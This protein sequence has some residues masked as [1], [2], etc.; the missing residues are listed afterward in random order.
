MVEIHSAVNGRVR[1]RIGKLYRSVH[2][3]DYLERK[4]SE[5]EQIVRATA[6]PLTGTL[7]VVSNG[8][9]T[10]QDIREVV[11]DLLRRHF[12][13]NGGRAGSGMAG[14]SK[15]ERTLVPV[16]SARDDSSKPPGVRR[17]TETFL[18]GGISRQPERTWWH[19]E[20]AE[21][22]TALNTS[23]ETGLSENAARD[24]LK[25]FGPNVLAESRK[26]SVL[27]L[28]LGQ[29]NSLPVALLG[30]AAGVSLLTGG[31]ADALVILSVVGINAAI[32]CATERQAEKTLESLK[33]LVR[34][35]AQVI[36]AGTCRDVDIVRVVPGDLVVLRPGTYVPADCRLVEA[37]HLTVDESA[38]TGESMP[39][40]KACHALPETAIPIGERVNMVH[41]G[42]LVTGGQGI[43]VAVATG[44]YTEIGRI[45]NLVENASAPETPMERQLSQIGNQLVLISSAVCT[46]IFSIGLFRRYGFLEMFKTSIS[47]AVAAVPEGLPT[48]ATTTLAIGI[49]TMRSRK[50]IMRHLEAVE[51]L[52]AIQTI[53]FD[54]TGTVTENRM[55]VRRIFTSMQTV[56]VGGSNGSGEFSCATPAMDPLTCRELIQLLHVSVLCS[57]TAVEQNGT[58]YALHG[59]STE[60][61]LVRTA[62][63][64]GIDPIRLREEYLLLKTNHRSE[65][66]HFMGTLHRS[67]NGGT[68]FALKGS[69]PE[70]LAMCQWQLIDGE[71]VPLTEE[72]RTIIEN[73]NENMAGDALRVLGFAFSE[74]EDGG[75]F[76]SP[77]SLTWL[78]L[79]GMADPIRKGVKE[80]IPLFHDAGIETILIT[81]DQSATAYAIGRELDL[82]RG[83]PLEIL[84]SMCL[85]DLEPDALRALSQ[86]V[87]VFSRVSPA[88]KLQIVQALQTAGKIVAMTGD[89]IND[90]PALKAADVGVALGGSGTD[91]AREVA[92]VVL[93]D[94]NLETMI[95]AVSHGRTV[96]ANIRK[97]IHF[98]LATNFSEIMLMFVGTATGLGSPLT[99]MQLLWIN[100]IS[101]IFPGLALALEGPEPDVM[102]RPPGDPHEAVIKAGDFK[103]LTFESGAMT[104]GALAAYGYGALRYGLGPVA[105]TLAF[106]SLTL[107]QLFH[108]VS[109]RSEQ[110]TI[111]DR[112]RL[113]RNKHLDLALGGSLLLQMLTFVMPGLRNLLGLT[114]LGLTDVL[115]VGST[116]LL[117]LLINESTKDTERSECHEERL[118]V[119]VGISD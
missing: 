38:L 74:G 104:A 34:P 118:Y 101:D 55:A 28:F 29:L 93:E 62:L 112:E 10:R 50:V 113:P 116:A 5:H 68:F 31:L 105:G 119:H 6:N 25:T 40:A 12:T 75:V 27:S 86:R 19:M 107:A 20:P 117:P 96:H 67:P 78:G 42:T 33:D 72:D 103:R 2:L 7:L 88:H 16:Q 61:A 9:L 70:V 1:Y 24:N 80:L 57:E 85:A 13:D 58:E 69:P 98:L 83:A 90:G 79:V 3:K 22:L 21:V 87:H 109:C 71:R 76:D 45:Q 77:A 26:R 30:I 65:D 59:S 11:E 36:R 43:A 73:E 115:I 32:G 91:V 114:S 102:K 94:D 47:L 46:L 17:M 18:S 15:E 56:V 82:G 97:A 99:A 39:V 49:N 53:C 84:D 54:K 14:P 111:F 41:M 4:L 44:R 48:V 35:E 95:A 100:L 108:A 64:A 52:G 81:G 110:H 63:R 8:G 92:D 106:Q 23:W 51:T 60:A 37:I 89:G 66:R